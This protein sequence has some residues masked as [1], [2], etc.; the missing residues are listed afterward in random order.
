MEEENLKAYYKLPEE[1]HLQERIELEDMKLDALM[2]AFRE[3][4]RRVESKVPPRQRE[5]RRDTYTVKG[6]MAYIRRRLASKKE[7][8]F[9][10]LF[11]EDG[12][13]SEVVTTFS[14]MLELWKNRYL[15]LTQTENFGD[16]IVRLNVEEIRRE[17]TE[18]TDE[19]Q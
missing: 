9:F 14:A 2:Q 11:E 16:I 1:M 10:D 13:K 15:N 3:V 18:E 6:K 17:D 4:L 7:V 8:S 5:I 12:N 19:Q